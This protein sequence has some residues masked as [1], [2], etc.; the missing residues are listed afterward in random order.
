[1]YDDLRKIS[2]RSDEEEITEVE[3]YEEYVVEERLFGL[4]A[5]QRLILAV[6]FLA[7]VVMMGA[8]LLLVTERVWLFG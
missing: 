4:T 7:V 1:M 8:I 5:L 6:L 2:D 3:D